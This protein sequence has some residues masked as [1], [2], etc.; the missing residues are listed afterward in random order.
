MN[1]STATWRKASRSSDK[2][3]NCV[4]VASVPNIVAL[5]D[6][7]DPNGGNILLSHQNFRHLTHTL[8]NL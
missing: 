5:R 7:K 6:S 2:G 8:K 4:E 3:D 1:L